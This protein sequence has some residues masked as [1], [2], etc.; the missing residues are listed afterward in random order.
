MGWIKESKHP[1]GS[2]SAEVM[3]RRVA[4]ITPILNSRRAPGHVEPDRGWE[5]MVAGIMG[6]GWKMHAWAVCSDN[7][8]GRSAAVVRSSLSSRS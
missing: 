2:G 6:V 4:G 5:V 8:G 7:E 1:D 3:G